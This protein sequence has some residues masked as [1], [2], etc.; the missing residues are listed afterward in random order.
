MNNKPIILFA[1]G[2]F[3]EHCLNSLAQ[4]ISVE[5]RWPVVVQS[6]EMDLNPFYDENRR[7]YDGN[8]LL[9][10]IELIDTE[11]YFKKIGLFQID[12]FI[13]IL[14]YIFGQAVFNGNSG[15]VSAF[16]LKNELYGLKPDHPL[17]FK[18]FKKVIIHELGHS[19]GL[20]H[21]QHPK[22]VMRSS[23]YVED[24]DQKSAHFC[25]SCKLK[26]DKLI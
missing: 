8:K 9:K 23:T 5:Y 3:D 2:Q 20:I 24:I 18:R 21:C 17:L 16:R 14:T 7:Q 10:A 11:T 26:L 22:C 12:L 15:I 13:P 1:I 6:V 19:L 4:D 25:S